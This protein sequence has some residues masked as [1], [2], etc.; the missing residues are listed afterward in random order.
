MPFASRTL[1]HL[2]Q[3]RSRTD[4]V[5]RRIPVQKTVAKFSNTKRRVEPTRF[6]AR[7]SAKRVNI[8]KI[9]NAHDEKLW[10]KVMTFRI[11]ICYNFSYLFYLSFL[12]ARAMCY[13]LI[14][15][16]NNNNKKHSKH[17]LR[18]REKR[19]ARVLVLKY[20]QSWNI[21]WNNVSI[22]S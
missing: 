15:T 13:V 10:I 20:K 6:S 2:P 17:K 19:S 22:L 12:Y 16:N 18:R 3:N 11:K 4:F 7:L 5:V 9:Q 8:R 14:A 1:L 21:I